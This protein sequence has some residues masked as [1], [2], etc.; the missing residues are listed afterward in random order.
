MSSRFMSILQHSA[1]VVGTPVSCTERK[2][3]REEGE[4]VAED[5]VSR[6]DEVRRSQKIVVVYYWHRYRRL[7]LA[8]L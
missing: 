2:E 7:V 5:I 8:V 4:V 6:R 1:T 3:E